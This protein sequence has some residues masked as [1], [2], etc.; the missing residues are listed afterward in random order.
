MYTTQNASARRALQWQ[1]VLT[2]ALSLVSLSACGGGDDAP[3]SAANA[4]RSM[5]LSGQVSTV[6]S[7]SIFTLEGVQ[8]D[9]AGA[10]Q[11]AGVI[12]AGSRLE[13][14]GQLVDGVFR[15]TRVEREDDN[16]FDGLEIWGSVEALNTASQRFVLRGI[17]ISYAGAVFDDGSVAALREG[18]LVEVEGRPA[19]DGKSV[20]AFRVD[21]DD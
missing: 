10:S 20:Q 12:Q 18:R 19:P 15:A 3:A 9:A 1:Y 13:V 5:E 16:D 17:D 4:P 11:N 14:E 21:F 7:P 8:V 6:T 2:G